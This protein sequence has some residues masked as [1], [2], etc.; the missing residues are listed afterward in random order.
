MNK[1]AVAGTILALLAAIFFF[2]VVASNPFPTSRL[3]SPPSRF[4]NI[5]DPNVNVGKE[6]GQ[7]MWT[8]LGIALA[9]SALVIFAAA[10]GCLVILRIEDKGETEND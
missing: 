5:T 10:A 2:A 7:F 4:V 6:D 9:G 1:I 3:A 8:N